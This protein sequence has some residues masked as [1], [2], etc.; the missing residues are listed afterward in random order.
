MAFV[1]PK[2]T[3]AEVVTSHP[4]THAVNSPRI[5]GDLFSLLLKPAKLLS[6]MNYEVV[7]KKDL[8]FAETCS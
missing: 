6:E 7:V 1:W 4:V 8:C 5:S 2:M 3:L